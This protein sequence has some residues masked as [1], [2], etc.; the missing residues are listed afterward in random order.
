[1][2]V[3]LSV[4]GGVERD[5]EELAVRDAGLARS[6]LAA[7]ALALARELDN[8]KNS[9]TS[10]AMCSRAL[11]ETLDRLWELAPEAEETDRL[12]D[13]SSRRA[14]RIARVAGA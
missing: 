2:I 6:G 12:D 13:L 1:M 8:S 10:R 14:S 11:V 9:A 5:L 4:V 3:E 7:A